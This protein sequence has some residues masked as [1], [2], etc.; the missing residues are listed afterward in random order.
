M[1]QMTKMRTKRKENTEKTLKGFSRT[2]KLNLFNTKEVIAIKLITTHLHMR[3][4]TLIL[5]KNTPTPTCKC[6]TL[7]K[8]NL[9]RNLKDTGMLQDHLSKNPLLLK[10]KETC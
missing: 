3:E 10:N 5:I 1:I 4:E 6:T 8:K 7:D 2:I 9:Q